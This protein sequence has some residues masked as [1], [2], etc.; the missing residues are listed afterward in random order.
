[1]KRYD[2]ISKY[3]K[4]ILMNYKDL[5]IWGSKKIKRAYDLSIILHDKISAQLHKMRYKC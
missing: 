3:K 5:F 1:M 4:I 2:I